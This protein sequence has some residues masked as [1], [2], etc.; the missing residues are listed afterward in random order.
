MHMRLIDQLAATRLYYHRPLPTLPDILLIDIPTSYS[1]EGLALDRYYPVILETLAEMH[2]FE[3]FLC[4]RRTELIAPSLLARRP[5]S[6][7]TDD[8][9]VAQYRPPAPGWP[10]LQL[11]CWPNRYTM[12]VPDPA[13]EFARGTYT[14][15]AF[16]TAADISAAELRLR[17]ALGT[18]EARHVRSISA[19]GGH[20]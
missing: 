1:G 7:R 17:A 19:L 13:E 6:L 2:E 14:V 12:M 15:D 18:N 3:T 16:D 20:A 11:C 9:V 8:I 4:E 5:S 10:W